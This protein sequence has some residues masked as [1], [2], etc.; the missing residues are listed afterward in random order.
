ME[1][2]LNVTIYR[3]CHII[4][5]QLQI[6]CTW[7][8]E[9]N[10]DWIFQGPACAV[11]LINLMFL[12]RIMWVSYWWIY[13]DNQIKISI[14]LCSCVPKK[15]SEQIKRIFFV[16]NCQ[17]KITF[18]Q[19]LITKLRSANTVETRQYRKASKALLVLIPL[20]GITYLV[21][22]AGPNEGVGSYIFVVARA[23]LLSTQ[24][25]PNVFINKYPFRPSSS[26]VLYI[27]H[28][29]HI[30]FNDSWILRPYSTLV[31]VAP[32]CFFIILF[33]S[34]FLLSNDYISVFVFEQWKY[35]EDWC[36]NCAPSAAHR[37]LFELI[38]RN[39]KALSS[40][41]NLYLGGFFAD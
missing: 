20:L 4:S 5:L 10:I 21:V 34:L 39:G 1:W 6:E 23:F 17:T 32:C 27:A 33:V 26:T 40:T 29:V 8:R 37:L 11:L 7:M 13:D 31:C 25:T 28:N 18:F 16:L 38:Q 30:I 22:L 14:S 24:V 19:V 3:I 12:F 35:H 36:W 9:T 41:I 15:Q 2:I